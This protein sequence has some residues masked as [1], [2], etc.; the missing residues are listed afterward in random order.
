MQRTSQRVLGAG[1]RSI[2][3]RV[4]AFL[5]MLL[6]TVAGIAQAAHIHGQW[7]PNS[8]I[9]IAAHTTLPPGTAEDACPLC[10]AMHSALPVTSF[11]APLVGLLLDINLLLASTRKPERLWYFAAWEISSPRAS[12]SLSP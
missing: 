5:C 3:L 1:P 10:T 11:S 7:L 8:A 4:A 9:Q 2:G 12:T 6:V